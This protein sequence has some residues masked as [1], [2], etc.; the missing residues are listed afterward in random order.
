MKLYPNPDHYRQ[1]QTAEAA[2]RPRPNPPTRQ[3][4]LAVS[5]SLTHNP[6][7]VLHQHGLTAVGSL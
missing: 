6:M 7:A 3:T 4:E 5:G 1:L 2:Y